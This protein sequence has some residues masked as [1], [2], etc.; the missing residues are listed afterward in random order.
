MKRFLAIFGSV[1]ACA[2]LFGCAHPITMNPDLATISAPTETKVIDKSVGY[3]IPD[4]L[5]NLEVTTAGGGGDKIRYF[6][7]RD[8][9]TGFYKA[10]S[11][12]FSKVTRVVDPKDQAA[13][14]ANG[15][16]LLF[17]PEITTV[18]SSD[19][20]VTWPPT[21]FS[22]NLVCSITD[23]DGKLIDTVR[24]NGAGFATF[25]EFKGNFS[26][27]AVNASND[28]LVKLMKEL[29]ASQALRK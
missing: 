4:S 13:L 20:I 28:V 29:S 11:E 10:L 23:P 5:R 8:I 6:P 16:S 24:I 18:S 27:A 15:V 25:S 26:L 19:S 2:F 22:I 14:R 3:H 12:V 21:Q 7:Y 1:L 17:T 9:E